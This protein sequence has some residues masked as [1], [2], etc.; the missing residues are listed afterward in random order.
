MQAFCRFFVTICKLNRTFLELWPSQV[1]RNVASH[2]GVLEQM[3]EL[4]ESE[5]VRFS[6]IRVTVLIAVPGSDSFAKHA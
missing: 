4:L 6:M 3:C 5:G 1:I 2:S